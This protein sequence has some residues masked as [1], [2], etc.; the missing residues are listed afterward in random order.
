MLNLTI[1]SN[2]RS[3][4]PTSGPRFELTDNV[5]LVLSLTDAS[6]SLMN[7]MI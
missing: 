4:I 1:V 7:V 2:N 6:T 3:P 5:L